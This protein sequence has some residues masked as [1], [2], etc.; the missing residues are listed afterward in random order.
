V[1]TLHSPYRWQFVLKPMALQTDSDSTEEITE[2]K[3]VHQIEITELQASHNQAINDLGKA[4]CQALETQAEHYFYLR[5]A[6]DIK[7]QACN[8]E[9]LVELAAKDQQLE[10]L[11]RTHLLEVQNKEMVLVGR[12]RDNDLQNLQLL[13]EKDA[14]ISQM[15]DIKQSSV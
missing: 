8:M 11:R 3:W 10:R 15:K 13:L 6:W 4:H 1:F 12:L 9:H 5:E 14:L 2:L 7:E